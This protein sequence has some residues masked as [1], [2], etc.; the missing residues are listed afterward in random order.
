MSRFCNPE[1]SYVQ[2]CFGFCPFSLANCNSTLQVCII[3]IFD[4][5]VLSVHSDLCP[6]INTNDVDSW[7]ELSE[8]DSC[9]I[10]VLGRFKYFGV[11]RRSRRHETKFLGNDY[12]TL[13]LTETEKREFSPTSSSNSGYGHQYD[14]GNAEKTSRNWEYFG[15]R[16]GTVQT[17]SSLL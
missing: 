1:N 8:G 6:S 16:Y 12:Y 10:C 3:Y 13:S 11:P 2:W 14:L 9:K 5:R 17:C 7:R 15:V 4:Y